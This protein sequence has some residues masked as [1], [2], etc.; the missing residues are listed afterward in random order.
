VIA[1][2][3]QT[4][5]DNLELLTSVA[6]QKV[7][8]GDETEAIRLFRRVI[9]IDPNHTVALNNLATLLAERRNQLQ[10]AREYIERAIENAGRRPALLDTLGT[11]MIRAGEPQQAV[12]ALE[13]AVAGVVTDPRYYFHLAVAYQ[14]LG[15][16]SEAKQALEI[17]RQQGLERAILTSGDRE[18]LTSLETELVTATL[19]SLD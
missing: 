6:V 9:E 5:G 14:R 13:E 4:H 3:L 1:S 12:A 19:P 16:D 10:E 7:T 17:S 11:I 2:A 8:E 18:L 15:R